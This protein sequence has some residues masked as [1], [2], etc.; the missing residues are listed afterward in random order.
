MDICKE[1]YPNPRSRVTIIISI[2]NN[3]KSKD[4]FNVLKI[5]LAVTIK[6]VSKT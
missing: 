5:K 6:D 2:S 3:K 1:T 4:S